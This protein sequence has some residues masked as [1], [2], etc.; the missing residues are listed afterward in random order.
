[1]LAWLVVSAG[2]NVV[3]IHRVLPCHISALSLDVS[4]HSSFLIESSIGWEAAC[5][6]D[7]RI[8]LSSECHKVYPHSFVVTTC[9][10]AYHRRRAA[11]PRLYCEPPSGRRPHRRFPLRRRSRPLRTRSS[12][13][14]L[15]YL[16]QAGCRP[17]PAQPR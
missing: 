2:T 13:S 14:L 4:P 5:C 11:L 9:L 6:L 8:M 16:S 1:M 10:D 12:G 7:E 17:H 3:S 15:A